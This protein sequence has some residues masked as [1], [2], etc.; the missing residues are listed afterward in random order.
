MIDL[1]L[2]WLLVNMRVQ[3]MGQFL[4]NRSK[5][6]FSPLKNLLNSKVYVIGADILFVLLVPIPDQGVTHHMNEVGLITVELVDF[7]DEAFQIMQLSNT[8]NTFFSDQ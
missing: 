6:I 1:S 4:S 7:F 8:R 3:P 2:I 5:L